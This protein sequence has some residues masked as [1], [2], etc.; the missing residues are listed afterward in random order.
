[1]PIMDHPQVQHDASYS[2]QVM[3]LVMLF[4]SHVIVLTVVVVEVA[5]LIVLRQKNQHHHDDVDYYR[6]SP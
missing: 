5:S 3:K 2:P 4:L 6:Q 1:M